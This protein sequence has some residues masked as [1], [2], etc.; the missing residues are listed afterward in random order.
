AGDLTDVEAMFMLKTVMDALG[1]PHMD[2]R[3]DGA[4]IDANV[5]AS[6]L[7]NTTI[8]GIE[9]ADACLLV[10]TNPRYEAPLINTRLRKR[11]LVGK[12]PVV[13]VGP[14]IDL[15]YPV[16]QPGND[17]SILEQMFSGE[18]PFSKLLEKAERPMVIIGQTA[19][20][21]DDAP[22]VL[23]LLYRICEK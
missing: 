10:G 8:A 7:F 18:H 4:F 13:S 16:E 6:Y 9:R 15:T 22:A 3:Q 14:E 11:S 12:F 19:L 20:R 2:C 23:N 21:R 17:L 5:R 1:S